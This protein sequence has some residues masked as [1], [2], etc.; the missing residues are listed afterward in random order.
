M[1]C[2][3]CGKVRCHHLGRPE[4]DQHTAKSSHGSNSPPTPVATTLAENGFSLF[5]LTD[6]RELLCTLCSKVIPNGP[7]QTYER[8]HHAQ[9]H[10]RSGEATEDRRGLPP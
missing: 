3:Y 4:D 7:N 9:R 1:T 10:I 8:A 2:H 6:R 5:E